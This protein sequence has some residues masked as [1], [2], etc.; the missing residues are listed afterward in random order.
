MRAKRWELADSNP[1]RLRTPQDIVEDLLV[2]R[3]LTD[4]DKCERFLNPRLADLADPL[5]LADMERAVERVSHALH[6]RENILIYSDYDVDGMSSSALLY[7]FLIKLGANVRVFIP[8]RLAEGYGLSVSGLEHA[9]ADGP[10]TLL[11]ALD[12]GTTNIAEVAWLNERGIDVVI[13][14]HHELHHTLPPARAFVNPQRGKLAA[15]RM[16]ATAGLVFKFCHA[17]LKIQQTPELFNLREHLDLVALGTIADLVPLLEDNRILVRH[18]LSQMSATLHPGLQ[19][20]ME[21]A[22]VRTGPTPATVG[23]TLAP[24]LNASGRLTAA[25]SG[26]ELL[27]TRDTARATALA[28]TLNT[29]NSERQHLELAAYR[30]ALEQ[31]DQQPPGDKAHCLVVASPNWHQGIVGIVASR[32]QRRFYKPA[33][34]IS[35]TDGE[36]KGS[37]RCIEGCS[38]MDALREHASLLHAYGGHAMASGLEIAADRVTEFRAAMNNWFRHRVNTELYQERLPVELALPGRALTEE[39]AQ[40]LGRLQPF[41]RKNEPPIFKVSGV[42]MHSPPQF[43]GNHHLKFTASADDTRFSAVGFTLAENMP[44]ADAYD[45]VGHWEMDDYTQRPLFRILDWHAAA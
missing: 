29:L 45:M 10:A 17:F 4:P 36:G 27:T 16:L 12:C 33:V 8:E 38:M 22:R 42:T 19:A 9:L 15:D 20:L 23:F 37:A 35:L 43:F 24:R 21:I 30:E 41:G 44:D 31:L 28:R 7:R 26:W 39:L 32:L 5:R 3:G 14:D 13:I 25:M 18:G 40:E 2:R 34:V 11:I 6:R 1:A